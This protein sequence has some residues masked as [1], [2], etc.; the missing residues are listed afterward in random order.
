MRRCCTFD[1]RGIGNSSVPD[2]YAAYRT[3]FMAAD[4]LALMD[5]LGWER[6]HVM[7]MSLGGAPAI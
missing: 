2:T 3:N 1:N 7:G 6:A 4:A 5:H